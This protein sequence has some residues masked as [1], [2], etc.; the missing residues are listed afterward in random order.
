MY[1]IFHLRSSEHNFD[2][3]DLVSYDA[4]YKNN[5]GDIHERRNEVIPYCNWSCYTEEK[6]FIDTNDALHEFYEN[7]K[8]NFDEIKKRIIELN[9]EIYICVAVS[10]TEDDNT[11][12]VSF[13]KEML[14]MCVELNAN[15]DVDI[16]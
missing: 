12:A 5:I 3:S 7:I 2:F 14:K 10:T 16:Y 1:I 11:F 4:K 6:Q 9:L 8:V 13:D 15:L